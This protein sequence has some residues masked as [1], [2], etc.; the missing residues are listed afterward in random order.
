MAK[1]GRNDPCPCGNKRSDN[2]PVKYKKCCWLKITPPPSQET[3]EEVIKIFQKM[4]SEKRALQEKGI[5]INYVHPCTYVN[6]RTNEKVK[7]WALG[8][9]LFHTRPEHETFHEFITDHLQKEV[10]GQ[11]WW[12]E[13]LQA[14][15]KHFLFR[16]FTQWNEWSRKNATEANKVDDHTWYAVTDGWAK[17]LSSLAFDICSLEHTQQ[18]PDH[19]LR[20][21]KNYGE[22]QGA[23]YEIAVAAIFSRLGCKIDFLDNER[24]ATPHCEFI[25]THIETGV[26]IAVEAKSRQRPGIKHATGKVDEKKLLRGDVQKLLNKALKQNPKDRPFVIFIDINAPLTPHVPMEKKKWFTDIQNMMNTYPAPTTETPDEY[27]GLFFTNFSPH[28]NGESE[29]FPNEHL[30]IIP[31]HS[32][33]AMPNP[34][35]GNML[36]SAVQNYGF[37]PNVLED[38]S[39]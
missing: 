14:Q 22:Y 6:P 10:L 38:K 37:V 32:N 25:A 7:A 9:K 20:R 15:Q 2:I 12:N 13:Q 39:R 33:Y 36:M 16:C 23:H 35:F 29:A 5:F 3:I 34:A 11:D 19:I 1:I 21:L 17:T 18:L 30:A 4:E 24:V 31:F 27:A 8:N 28:Y 26:S